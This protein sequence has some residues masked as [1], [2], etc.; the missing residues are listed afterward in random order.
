MFASNYNVV[1]LLLLTRFSIFTINLN[2]LFFT[3]VL[4]ELNLLIVIP[5]LLVKRA[6]RKEQTSLPLKY[7]LIQVIGSIFLLLSL[8]FTQIRFFSLRKI[9]LFFAI[10]LILKS[11]IPPLHFWFPPL[12]Y[13]SNYLQSFVLLCIQKLIPLFLIGTLFTEATFIFVVLSRLVGGVIGFNQNSMIKVLAYSSIVH[14]SWIISGIRIRPLAS[15]FYFIVYSFRTFVILNMLKIY[16]IKFISELVK[17]NS[18][19]TLKILFI[20]RFLTLSGTPPFIGFFAKIYVLKIIVT[21]KIFF[22]RIFLIIGSSLSFFYYS[23]LIVP[24][25]LLTSLSPK[26]KYKFSNN[27][28]LTSLVLINLAALIIFWLSS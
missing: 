27:N 1:F 4:I 14:S 22:L 20:I 2:S 8:I 13:L 21:S 18:C 23:R 24:L 19:L 10:S 16:S 15:C 11:G 17:F 6:Y 3:W 7:F 26:E 5:L 25:F 12:M 9:N 28:Y